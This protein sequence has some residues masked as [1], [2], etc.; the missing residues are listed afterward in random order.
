MLKANQITQD[1]PD[2]KRFQ[3]DNTSHHHHPPM[4]SP[5]IL[6]LMYCVYCVYYG[7]RMIHDM[8]CVYC[9]CIV[10]TNVCIV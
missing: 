1:H 5:C 2:L 8:H 9:V 4:V 6:D 3:T 10:C 7:I